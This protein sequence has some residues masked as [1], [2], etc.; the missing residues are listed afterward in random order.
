MGLMSAARYRNVTVRG[1]SR[2][3]ES[4]AGEEEADVHITSNVEMANTDNQKNIGGRAGIYAIGCGGARRR[5]ALLIGPA[6]HHIPPPTCP[7]RL[8]LCP[9]AAACSRSPPL[10]PPS[11][12]AFAIVYSP[13]LTARRRDHARPGYASRRD[14]YA[15]PRSAPSP[16]V[17]TVTLTRGRVFLS[18]RILHIR[19]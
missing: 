12:S 5:L 16:R 4:E 10:L 18:S 11:V 9:Q 17:W 6:C 19:T 2:D 8:A 13:A 14:G 3:T 15:P 1:Q 7:V